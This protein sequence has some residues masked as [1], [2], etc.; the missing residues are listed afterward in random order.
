[1]LVSSRPRSELDYLHCLARLFVSQEHVG[2]AS[3]AVLRIGQRLV[4]FEVGRGILK[5]MHLLFFG[6]S[7]TLALTIFS[8]WV[9]VLSADVVFGTAFYQ[10]PTAQVV[11]FTH[12]K[13]THALWSRYVIA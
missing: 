10:A 5:P 2:R 7:V 13:L 12:W 4:K 11:P 6:L 3:T 8:G 1:M 9:Q